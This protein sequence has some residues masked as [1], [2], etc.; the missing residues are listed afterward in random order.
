MIL[1][2]TPGKVGY[3]TPSMR[4]AVI[5][6]LPDISTLTVTMLFFTTIF[7]Y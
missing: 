7:H 1:D 4:F 6:I 5:L 3:V 2:V